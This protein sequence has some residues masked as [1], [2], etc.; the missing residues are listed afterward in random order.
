MTSRSWEG[1]EW[2]D[3]CLLLLHKRYEDHSL[4]EVP[5]RDRGDLG[6]EAFS[7]DGCA[8][9][10]YAAQEPLS[11]ADLYANQRDKLTADLAKL[12]KYAVDLQAILGNVK[13]RRYVFMVP[14]FDSR[15]LLS[16][17]VSKSSEVISWMLNFVD[18]SFRVIVVTDDDYG[19]ER[20]AV[21]A[22]PEPLVLPKATTDHHVNSWANSNPGVLDDASRKFNN[23]G[24]S[25]GGLEGALK[26][27]AVQYLD[28]ENALQQLRDRYPDHWETARQ[29]LSRRE[30]RLVF[31]FPTQ[32]NDSLRVVAEVADSLALELAREAPSI[33]GLV[34]ETIAWGMVAEWVIRCPLD[35]QASR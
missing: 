21:I 18:P 11:T 23:L 14:R 4:Q 16:H 15:R 35:F 26:S 3:Y 29:C 33:S 10:C 1:R 30:K 6:I 25:G 8:F 19:A 5:D 13:V 34:A 7:L 32:R 28:G 20:A 27:L 31:E 17:A 12:K 2:Q 9:Q 22:V 24:L